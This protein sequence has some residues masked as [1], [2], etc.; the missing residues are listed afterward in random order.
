MDNKVLRSFYFL[1]YFK[2]S[3]TKQNVGM[4]AAYTC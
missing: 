1:N 3:E 2:S 4:L